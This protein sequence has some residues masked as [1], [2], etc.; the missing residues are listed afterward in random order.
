MTEW[1]KK[2]LLYGTPKFMQILSPSTAHSPHPNSFL[3]AGY[4]RRRKVT[5]QWRNLGNTTLAQVQ[6]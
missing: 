1:E 2:N 4:G 6:G 5:S 3:K